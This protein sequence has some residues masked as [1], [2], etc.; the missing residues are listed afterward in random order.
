[1][2]PASVL[3]CRHGSL[4]SVVERPQFQTLSGGK[5][6]DCYSHSRAESVKQSLPRLRMS[7]FAARSAWLAMLIEWRNRSAVALIADYAQSIPLA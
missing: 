3:M 5:D 7:A 6:I 1:M 4:S 2:T